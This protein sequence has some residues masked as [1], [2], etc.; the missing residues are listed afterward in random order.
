MLNIHLGELNDKIKEDMYILIKG[1]FFLTIGLPWTAYGEGMQARERVVKT[2]TDYLGSRPV[3]DDI[4]NKFIQTIREYSPED[5]EDM[6]HGQG[7]D[8]LTGLMFVGHNTTADT[9]VFTVK[10]VG[11]N[12]HVLTEIRVIPSPSARSC[13][14]IHCSSSS[15]HGFN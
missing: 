2:L 11:K 8:L 4:Y 14:K 7:R 5:T 15:C 1:M 10:Y 6:L 9:M 13:H 3:K 12:P